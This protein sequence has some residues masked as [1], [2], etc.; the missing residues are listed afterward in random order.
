L[1]SHYFAHRF[2]PHRVE[3]VKV[4]E[5]CA[6]EARGDGFVVAEREPKAS[7]HLNDFNTGTTPP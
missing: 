4:C 5:T 3:T 6:E 1:G 2:G 7:P